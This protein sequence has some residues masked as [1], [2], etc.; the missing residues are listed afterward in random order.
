[1][2][3]SPTMVGGEVTRRPMCGLRTDP[4]TV[5]VV[6]WLMAPLSDQAKPCGRCRQ[7]TR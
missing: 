3:A 1:M 6:A 4:A 7:K 2:S 5:Q